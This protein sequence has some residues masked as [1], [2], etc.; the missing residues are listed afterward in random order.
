MGASIQTTG[1]DHIVLRVE[2]PQRSLDFYVGLLGMEPVR[3][4]EWKRGEVSFP[5]AR[6]SADSIIDFAPGKREGVNLDHYCIVIEPT[7]L[8]EIATSGTF[9]VD[10]GPVARFGARGTGRSL[11]VRDPDDNLI[12]LRH[13]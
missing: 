4:D 10:R 12:E 3:V 5:S 2:D 7:D 1:F 9:N 13:Y 8:D 6:I 11:Y